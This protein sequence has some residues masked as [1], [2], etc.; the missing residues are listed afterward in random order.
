MSL[1]SL[2]TLRGLTSIPQHIYIP[3]L[4]YNFRIDIW[5]LILLLAYPSW[6]IASLWGEESMVMSMAFLFMGLGFSL[7]F[8]KTI[9]SKIKHR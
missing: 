6:F 4:G 3:I 7:C 8:R 9:S 5:S 2:L 1:A